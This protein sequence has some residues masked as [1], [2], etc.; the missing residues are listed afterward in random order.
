MFV[1]LMKKIPHL[2]YD[3]F[4]FNF[5][6]DSSFDRNCADLKNAFVKI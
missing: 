3:L 5:G 4:A 2:F 6:F 1:I